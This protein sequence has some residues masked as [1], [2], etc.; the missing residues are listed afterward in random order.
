MTKVREIMRENVITVGKDASLENISKVM[1]NNRV[2]SVIILENKKPAGV[3]VSEDIVRAV[4]ND[5]NL[6]KLKAANFL[7]RGVITV[8]ADENILK[9]SKL[10]VKKNIKRIP[11]I[12]KGRLVGIVSD[13]EI[14]TVAPELIN[15]LSEKLKMRIGRVAKPEEIISGICED[16][17]SYSDNLKNIAGRWVCEDCRETEA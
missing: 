16:C 9:V 1:T 14:L 2:G 13:K 15:I 10:M 6:K 7:K 3:V 11:V 17:G 12:D 8:S 5:E 4:A